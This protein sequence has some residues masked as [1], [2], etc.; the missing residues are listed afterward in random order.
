MG[1][2]GMKDFLFFGTVAF[3]MF[4]LGPPACWVASKISHEYKHMFDGDR[5]YTIYNPFKGFISKDEPKI[6]CPPGYRAVYGDEPGPHR[7]STYLKLV[8][9]KED[10]LK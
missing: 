6:E 5:D 7:P 2:R 10:D 9:M 8:C 4:L 1:T 3:F